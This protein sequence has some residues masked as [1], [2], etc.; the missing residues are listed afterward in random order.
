LAH[1]ETAP[2]GDSFHLS[3]YLWESALD[4]TP[5]EI[6]AEAVEKLDIAAVS[7]PKK[8]IIDGEHPCEHGWVGSDD[9]FSMGNA[10]FIW[11]AADIHAN[12]AVVGGGGGGGGRFATMVYYY[13]FPSS[14]S[15][16]CSCVFYASFM[17]CIFHYIIR[18][19]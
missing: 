11:R 19:F 13:M 14:R 5:V 10:A 16:S 6:V 18:G 1:I 7:F 12:P 9:L 2:R 17:L 4:D 8:E 15:C 3:E